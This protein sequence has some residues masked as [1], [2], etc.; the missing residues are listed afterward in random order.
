MGELES[1]RIIVGIM[2]VQIDR[3]LHSQSR[4]KISLPPLLGKISQCSHRNILSNP[5]WINM[6]SSKVQERFLTL[7]FSQDYFG[8]GKELHQCKWGCLP[9]PESVKIPSK[10][11]PNAKSEILSLPSLGSAFALHFMSACQAVKPWHA[12]PVPGTNRAQFEIRTFLI[13]DVGFHSEA[14]KRPQEKQ[15]LGKI[16]TFKIHR[17]V[18]PR[19]VVSVN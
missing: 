12:A 3:N 5:Y 10:P 9:T 1:Q 8:W 19:S 17:T 4:C 6:L 15:N 7:M 18:N 13:Q 14:M 16:L 2:L 11:Q